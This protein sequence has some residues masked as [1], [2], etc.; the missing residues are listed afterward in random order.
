MHSHSLQEAPFS[1]STLLPAEPRQQAPTLPAP[2]LAASSQLPV[3]IPG[4]KFSSH[5]AA[6]SPA[7]LCIPL[8][9]ETIAP[10]ALGFLWTDSLLSGFCQLPG[11][12]SSHLPSPTPTPSV[13][14][15]AV[16][17]L[18]A[19]AATQ[20]G[21]GPLCLEHFLDLSLSGGGFQ[22]SETQIQLLK[23]LCLVPVQVAQGNLTA[24]MLPFR[25]LGRILYHTC[26]LMHSLTG[27]WKIYHN[28]SPMYTDVSTKLIHAKK[29]TKCFRAHPS[30]FQFSHF[31]YFINFK[32]CPLYFS[33]PC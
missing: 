31:L 10:L 33:N 4:L 30:I 2:L 19:A 11:I 17:T 3:K 24:L 13:L 29:L 20:P 27:T 18:I 9:I 12:V 5:L 15:S 32:R 8:H 6:L 28:L 25:R 14:L 1:T 22:R 7:H 16:L 23:Y 21:H 26:Q